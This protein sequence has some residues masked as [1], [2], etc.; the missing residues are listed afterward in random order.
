MRYLHCTR[1]VCICFGKRDACV[2]GYTYVDYAGDLDKRRSTSSY[3]F[4]FA[5]G[6]VS[7]RSHSQSCT[8]MSTIEAKYIAVSKACKEAIWLTWLVRD[9]GIAIEMPTL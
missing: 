4:M 2:E 9:L 3:V 1:D 8:S 5:G 7:W 6:T